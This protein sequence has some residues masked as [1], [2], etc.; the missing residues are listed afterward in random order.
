M[1]PRVAGTGKSFKGAALYYMHDKREAGEAVRLSSDRV[2][3]TETRG[4]ATDNP[5]LAWKLMAATAM[6]QARLKA[7][8]GIK[9][10]GR[11]TDQ[12]VYAYSLG[13][14]PD[15]KDGLTKAEMLRAGDE[16][17]RAIGA[18]DRQAIIIAH[19]D[20]AHPHIH[21]IVNRVSPEDGR[22]L[23]LKRDHLT[24]S[25]WAESYE[26]QRGHILCEQRVDNNSRRAEGEFV[27]YDE[28]QPHHHYKQE[29]GARAANENSAALARDQQKALD[30]KLAADTR[31]MRSRHSQAW[32]GLTERYKAQSAE[33][34]THAAAAAVRAR[35]SIKARFRP[36][37]RTLYRR[38]EGERDDFAEREAT[39]AGK[40]KNVVAALKHRKVSGMDADDRG[41]MA[42]AFTFGTNQ[43]ARAAAL[44]KLHRAQLRELSAAQR[45][46]VGAALHAVNADCTAL[47]SSARA[48]FTADRQALIQRQD[49]EKQQMRQAWKRRHDERARAF[50]TVRRNA[51][52]RKEAKAGQRPKH[53]MKG[54]R[55]RADHKSAA[56]GKRRGRGRRRVRK[57][58]RGDN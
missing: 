30:A 24:L 7:E 9:A 13:W 52:V 22:M 1:V 51:E 28:T 32:E 17:L 55:R 58:S 44:D 23:N 29:K 11:K 26:K 53:A 31:A 36:E 27:R 37:W 18:G 45:A 47:L 41:W 4:L 50:E 35:E 40:V 3:W 21:I 19:N 8:A 14:H 2:A 10:T 48:S 38:Q 33:I 39:I 42:A 34:R 16:S 43:H 20:T 6:D 5:D 12:T 25:K 57:R 49:Q 56:K 54:E 46:Q 15:E